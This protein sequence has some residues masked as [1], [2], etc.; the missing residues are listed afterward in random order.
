MTE[1][2]APD[3]KPRKLGLL[4]WLTIVL[5]CLFLA[6]AAGF[7]IHAWNLFPGVQISTNGVIAMVLGVFF[8]LLVGGALMGLIFWSHRKG[9][10]R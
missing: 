8:S 1:P 10:D 9:Y 4:G 6:A 5:L 2:R 7:A 3:P